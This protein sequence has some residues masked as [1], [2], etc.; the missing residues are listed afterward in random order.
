[1]KQASALSTGIQYAVLQAVPI[2]SC[3]CMVNQ[4]MERLTRNLRRFITEQ[5]RP[6]WP[7]PIQPHRESVDVQLR[8]IPWLSF[9][10]LVAVCWKENQLVTIYLDVLILLSWKRLPI[11]ILRAI[12]VGNQF[13]H[14]ISFLA[15]MGQNFFQDFGLHTT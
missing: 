12:L 10:L 3:K 1:M 5:P 9:E 11:I 6:P 15:A 2:F 13:L 14:W 7:P 8:P 4:S